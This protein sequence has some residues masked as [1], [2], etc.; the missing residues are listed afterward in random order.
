[1]ATMPEESDWFPAGWCSMS[2]SI[3]LAEFIAQLRAELTRA[4]AEG[5]EQAIK[6]DCG[7]I[8]PHV[9]V[10]D[11]GGD[12]RDPDRVVWPTWTAGSQDEAAS[13]PSPLGDVQEYWRTAG[14]RLGD[15]AKWRGGD[16]VRD[17]W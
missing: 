10:G 11:V 12:R 17:V 2:L 1:V 5:E 14:N 7:P 6:F 13:S 15:S 16:Y 3:E 9:F 4:L 8:G